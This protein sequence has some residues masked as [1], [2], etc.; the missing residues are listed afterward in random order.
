MSYKNDSLLVIMN[1]YTASKG[2]ITSEFFETYDKIRDLTASG[3]GAFGGGAGTMGTWLTN[4]ARYIAPSS[5]MSVLGTQ[6]MNI[7]GTSY[8]SSPSSTINS[9]SNFGSLS[10]MTG[11]PSGYAAGIGEDSNSSTSYGIGGSATGY[12]SSIASSVSSPVDFA[13]AALGNSTGY[14][15][16]G[17]NW[18]IPTAGVISGIGGIAQAIAPY[19]GVF[20]I[21]A[22]VFANVT[23]GYGHS[24]LAGYQNASQNVLNNADTILTNKVQNL[25]A[26]SKMLGAQS[27]VIK[28]M[29]KYKIE[30][31][32]KIAQDL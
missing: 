9:S 28:K 12:A 22:N 24:L 16:F 14:T 7:P 19:S 15:G 30:A 25:E 23:Q 13:G 4:I 27:D 26:V 32:T 29:I 3:S 5:F 17:S 10:T 2:D 1:K 11:F 31:D 18:V 21:A 6:A 8:Y 20:G